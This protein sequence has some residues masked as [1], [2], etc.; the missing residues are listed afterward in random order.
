[1]NLP[2]GHQVLTVFCLRFV[3][4]FGLGA[5]MVPGQGRAQFNS[6]MPVSRSMRPFPSTV[7]FL[8]YLGLDNGFGISEGSVRQPIFVTDVT[9][10]LWMMQ[11]TSP[12]SLC[13]ASWSFCTSFGYLLVLPTVRGWRLDNEVSAPRTKILQHSCHGAGFRGH[14]SAKVQCLAPNDL[15]V[16]PAQL[17]LEESFALFKCHGC[18]SFSKPRA[19]HQTVPRC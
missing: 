17:S 16:S 19:R 1:M 18:A 2:A 3:R 13:G 9:C 6:M 12:S 11:L 14:R 15:D 4:F 5:R 8:H 7:C 10:T